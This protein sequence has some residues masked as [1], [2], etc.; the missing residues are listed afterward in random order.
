MAEERFGP[1][2]R[3]RHGVWFWRS[4][5][6]LA[7]GLA[8]VAFGGVRVI[9]AGGGGAPAPVLPDHAALLPNLAVLSGSVLALVGAAAALATAR[10][11]PSRRPPR[12]GGALCFTIS[13]KPAWPPASRSTTTPNQPSRTPGPPSRCRPRVTLYRFSGP[14]MVRVF[15][16][17][18]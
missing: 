5:V 15:R 8:L 2:R 16:Q 1:E 4:L 14:A 10:S 3:P 9:A 7:L 6:L 18:R 11:A 13:A 17:D 12:Y